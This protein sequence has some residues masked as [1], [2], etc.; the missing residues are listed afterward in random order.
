MIAL[1]YGGFSSLRRFNSIISL[2][3]LVYSIIILATKADLDT[4]S[5]AFLI[6]Y[7]VLVG[8][9]ELGM[10]LII[11]FI[12]LSPLICCLCCCAICCCSG[13]KGRQISVPVKNATM[14]DIL[15]CDGTCSICYQ[16][17]GLNEQI[18]VLPC[19][20]KHLFHKGCLGHWLRIKNTCPN[21]RAV[22]PM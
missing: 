14:E 15:N 17:V 10:I 9:S 16:N 19:S 6:S 2:G 3:S 21:C 18:Y 22:I 8:L 7:V 13:S 11:I 20:P 4:L 5:K 1:L 12:A